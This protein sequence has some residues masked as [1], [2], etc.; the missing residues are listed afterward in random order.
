MLTVAQI[1]GG[2]SWIFRLPSVPPPAGRHPSCCF[3]LYLLRRPLPVRCRKGIRPGRPGF[4][5]L[6]LPFAYILHVSR[7]VFNQSFLFLFFILLQPGCSFTERVSQGVTGNP[8]AVFPGY[9]K[10]G[11]E[12]NPE[13]H[14]GS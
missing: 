12:K 1:P 7:W 3:V 14:R 4:L 9:P 11:P 2:K 10:E 5:R 6:T 8:P 13:A